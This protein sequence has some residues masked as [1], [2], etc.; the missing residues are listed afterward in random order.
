[1]LEL[2]NI[3]KSFPGLYKPVLDKVDLSLREGEFCVV[4]GANGSGKS[5]LLRT[6]SGQYKKDSGTILVDKKDCDFNKI[7]YVTQ[8]VN[9]GTI[10]EMTLLENMALSFLKAKENGFL[11]YGGYESEAIKQIK[12]LDIGLE[13]FL[14][15]PLYH[16]SGSQRQMIATIMAVCSK[17]KVLLLDEHTSALDPRM[18]I[19][20]ME[21]SAQVILEK[22]L[23]CLMITHKFDDAIKYGDSIIMLR[24]GKVV[25]DISGSMSATDGTDKSRLEWAKDSLRKI[26]EQLNDQ[27]YLSLVLF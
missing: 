13:K 15:E 24:E 4:I 19:R 26:L 12:V 14:Y 1:M 17:P 10:P 21:Y 16:L 3:S 22:K 9:M 20:L 27:D 25:L 8:D 23:T 6:I 7:A 2:K 11:F 18:Q 5:S